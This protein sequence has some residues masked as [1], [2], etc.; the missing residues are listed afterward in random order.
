MNDIRAL[1]KIAARRLELNSFIGRLHLTAMV[2]AGIAL[3]LMLA[4]RISAAAFVPWVWVGPALGVAMLVV[5]FALWMRRR[6][7]ENHV[8]LV[9]DERLDLREKLS[10]ALHCQGR[11]DAFAQ[12]AIED[13]VQTARN[14]KTRE[15]V[16]RRFA[17][18]APAGWWISPL[19]AFAAIMLGF[20]PQMDLFAREEQNAAVINAKL[21]AQQTVDAM[22]KVFD[23]KPELAKALEAGDLSKDGLDH[24]ALKRPEDIKRDVLRKATDFQKKLDEILNGEKGKT[25]EAIEESLKQLKAPEDGAAKELAEALANGDFQKAQQALNEMM[26]KAKNGQLNEE[27]KKQLAE[28]LQNIAEQLDKLAQQQQKLEEALKQ[29]GMDPNLA[30][31]A[32]ALQQALQNNQ[33]LNQQQKQQLQQMAQAQ[34]AACK[35]CQGMGQACKQMAQACKGGQMGQMG[36]GAGQMAQQLGEMEMLQQLLQEAQ[37][38]ANQCQGQCQ[39]LGQGLNM[40][41]AMQQWMQCNGGM[42]NRGQGQGGK[43]PIAPTPTGTK[44]EQAKVNTVE[45]DIIARQL[46]EGPQIRGDSKVKLVKVIEEARK[47]FDEGQTEEQIHIK[48]RDPQMHYFGELEKITKAKEAAAEEKSPE[49]TPTPPA[50]SAAPGAGTS[51]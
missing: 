51:N 43:A 39:G 35:A 12:A 3:A 23:D 22:V 40:N 47:G 21:E 20:I 8:A 44:V 25:A 18:T 28:Q 37:A 33:N 13:A 9:V 42:G 31:N 41:Q 50:E 19:A 38:A 1:L 2:F 34:Q 15:L 4:D 48:Y 49:A 6:S 30:Q 5:A 17:I 29:A 24:D 36:Q 46:F 27:Q 11:D 32:Q 26:E 45:G 16:R 10:T 7:T 14:G